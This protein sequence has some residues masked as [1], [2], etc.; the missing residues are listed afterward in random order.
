MR[1]QRP[2]NRLLRKPSSC[3]SR[4]RTR[5]GQRRT[6]PGFQAHVATPMGKGVRRS[7]ATSRRRKPVQGVASST[8]SHSLTD[9]RWTKVG[10]WAASASSRVVAWRDCVTRFRLASRAWSARRIDPTSD[11]TGVRRPNECRSCLPSYGAG[12]GARRLRS[13]AHVGRS[14]QKGD[15]SNSG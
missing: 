12:S 14:A 4:R 1:A 7:V 5:A 11:E 6:S 10:R 9:P 13:A 2:A 15:L 8:R 3:P